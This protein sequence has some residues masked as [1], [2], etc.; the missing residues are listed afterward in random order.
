MKLSELIQSVGDENVA[1]QNILHSSPDL[2][3]GKKEGTITFSTDSAKT[4][5]LCRQ[6]ATGEAGQWTALVVWIPTDKIPA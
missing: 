1:L 2:R 3:V 6:A 5:D 4:S